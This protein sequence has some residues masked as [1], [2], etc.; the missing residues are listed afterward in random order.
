M[1]SRKSHHAKRMAAWRLTKDQRGECQRCPAP[2][3]FDTR[4]GKRRR[5][6][7]NHL[8]IDAARK[9]GESR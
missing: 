3:Y 5:L 6:C 8:E 7:F 9:K 4:T 1:K 2:S